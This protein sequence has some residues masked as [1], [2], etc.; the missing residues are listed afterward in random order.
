[1]SVQRENVDIKLIAIDMDGTLLNDEQLISDENRKA[2][3]EAEDKGVYMVISTGRTLMT[4][5]ELA[6]SLELSSFLITANGSEIWDSNFNLVERKLLHT[7]HIKMMWDLRNKHNTNFW[8]S[9]VNKVWRGEFPENIT[10]HEW[11]KF[12]FDIEDDDIRNEVLAE[13]RKNKE[14]EITNSSPTNI[15]VNALGINKA[16]ALAKVSEKLGFT[17]EHVM[18][19]GDSLN[20]I[21]MIKEAGLGVAMGNAQDIVKETADWITDTNIEDGVAKAIRHWVL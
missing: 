10:D 18:A 13:L 6:E 1:M 16:A 19:M 7:D 8:A 11:L 3:R 20:D 4:C 9:T 5:R 2:I 14:L 15:E 12:G 17:M 21:A